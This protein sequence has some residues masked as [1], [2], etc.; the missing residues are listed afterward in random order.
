MSRE[1][2]SRCIAAHHQ[3][4]VLV[5][6]ALERG[7]DSHRLLRGTGLFQEQIA[8]GEHL[9]S[10]QQLLALIANAQRLLAADDAS[11]LFGQ[12]Q[13][14]GH[15]G[16][17]SHALQHAA[18]LHEALTWLGEQRA[19][20]SPLLRPRLQLDE[21]T[22]WLF[23]DDSY[24]AGAQQRFL[25]E[26]AMTAVVSVSRWLADA[27]LPWQFHLRG[28]KPRHVEQ[29]WVHLGEALH[30]NQPLDAMALPRQWLFTP[31]RNASPT[32]AEAARRQARREM[33]AEEEEGSLREQLF[34]Y[35]SDN[36]RRQPQLESAA[37]HFAISPATLKRKLHKHGTH[38]QA[39]LDYARTHAALWLYRSRGFASDEV[40]AWLNFSD[41]ANFRRSFKRWTGLAPS[42][43]MALL[44]RG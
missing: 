4:A 42:A 35:L 9:I 1:C 39:E 27:A 2:D 23:W 18:N 24:G 43:L 32:A 25:L 38:F 11:F 33:S 14:P 40:A 37:R 15:C 8:S 13:L 29:Y 36:L 26:A 17:A 12:R 41:A 21:Q 16:A 28:A 3:P 7:I 10:P 31:W 22:A 5:D 6:L 20:L 19:R 30:F 44:P 34:D